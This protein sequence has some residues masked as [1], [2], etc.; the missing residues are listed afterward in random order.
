MPLPKTFSQIEKRLHIGLLLCRNDP[1]AAP[2]GAETDIEIGK[3]F[4]RMSEID[5]PVHGRA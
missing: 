1:G 3:V 5:F 2:L 4:E